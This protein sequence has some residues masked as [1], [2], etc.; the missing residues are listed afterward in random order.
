MTM[1]GGQMPDITAAQIVAV[2]GNAIAVAV[3][4][5]IDLSTQQQDA[6]MALAGS[7]GAILVLSDSHLRSKRVEAHAVR[8][9]AEVQA[10]ATAPAAGDGSQNGAPPVTAEEGS[11]AMGTR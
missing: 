7:L 3:A 8:V 9:A 6:L 4:F 1:F 10:A 2:F 5:G 11:L